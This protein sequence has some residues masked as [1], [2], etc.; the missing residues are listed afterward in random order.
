MTDLSYLNGFSWDRSLAGNLPVYQAPAM[1]WTPGVIQG[2]TTRHG[3]VSAAPYDALNL[4]AHVQD[5]WEDVQENR[6]RL[7]SRLGFAETQVA[8]A[9]QVHGDVVQV[10]TAGSLTPAA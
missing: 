7:W 2:F 6:R 9:E 5:K 1:A 4:G 8:M 10:V 3:G